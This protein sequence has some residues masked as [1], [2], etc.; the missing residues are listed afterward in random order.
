MLGISMHIR[1]V[2][3]ETQTS[4]SDLARHLGICQGAPDEHAEQGAW[5][6][7]TA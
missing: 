3:H 1:S 5:V 6:A 7:Q 2:S 4:D